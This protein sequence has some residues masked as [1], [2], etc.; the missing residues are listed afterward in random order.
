M[1]CMIIID[2]MYVQIKYETKCIH[3]HT[4][5][6]TTLQYTILYFMI[7]KKCLF[8]QQC[9]TPHRHQCW[10]TPTPQMPSNKMFSR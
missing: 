2:I 5:M 6:Y 9:R 3:M 7:Q 4:Y 8:K 10:S 1:T